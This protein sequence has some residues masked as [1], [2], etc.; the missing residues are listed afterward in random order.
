MID[1]RDVWLVLAVAAVVLYGISVLMQYR[2]HEVAVR[3]HNLDVFYK[4]L[5]CDDLP[6]KGDTNVAACEVAIGEF[7]LPEMGLFTR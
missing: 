7:V 1:R 6:L 4:S 2:L 3:S 5:T